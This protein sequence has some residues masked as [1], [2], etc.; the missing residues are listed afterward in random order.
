MFTA[1]FSLKTYNSNIPEDTVT[2][3]EFTTQNI[4]DG[5]ARCLRVIRDD[6]QIPSV[7]P[8]SMSARF[9]LGTSLAT[10]CQVSVYGSFQFWHF[11][12]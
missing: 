8:A 2:L 12:G 1:Y 9:R 10:A 5:T 4:V 11:E 7:L 3:K 6:I